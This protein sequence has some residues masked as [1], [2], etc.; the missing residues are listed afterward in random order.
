VI[1]EKKEQEF[2]PNG[3]S[4][5]ARQIK[6]A[7]RN[8][9]RID[10]SDINDYIAGGGYKGFERALAMSS[11]EIISEMEASGLRGRGGAGFPAAAK[12]AAGARQRNFPKYI[13]C[14]GDEGD[15]G[16]FMDGSILEGDPHS[17]IEGMLIAALAIG[18]NRDS[19]IF[20]MNM[21]RRAKVSERLLKPQEKRDT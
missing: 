11:G 13:V 18:S 3:K 7:L 21:S 6:I 1:S 14:N 16:A 17:V 12:W 9:G 20:A 10:P 2:P 5:Y 15:P 4:F 19:S 8:V